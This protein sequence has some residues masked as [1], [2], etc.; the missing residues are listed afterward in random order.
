MEHE[1]TIKIRVFL[2][3]LACHSLPT[4]DVLSRRNMSTRDA[5]PLCGVADSWRHALLACT[6]AWCT[7]ALADPVLVSKMAASEE[8][9]A[10]N[11]LFQLNEDFDWNLFVRM[12]VTL[13]SIWFARRQA[14]HEGIFQSSGQTLSFV[15][16]Y[17]SELSQVPSQGPMNNPGEAGRCNEPRVWI[18]S[19]EGVAKI[20]VD[21]A[22]ARNRRGGAVA[23]VCRDHTGIY[24]GSSAVVFNGTRDPT[25]LETY[26]CREGM[27]LADDLLQ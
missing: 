12:V 16:R 23:A 15:E 13:W 8:P 25:I 9:R 2:W 17:I 21:G 27:A 24:L 14:I 3:R 1:S 22:L 4:T 19:L 20:N 26:A 7:W 6:H 11:W 10:K 18:P 5:C